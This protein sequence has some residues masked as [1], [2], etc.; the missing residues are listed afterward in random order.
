[1]QSNLPPDHSEDEEG[2]EVPVQVSLPLSPAWW[3]ALHEEDKDLLSQIITVESLLTASNTDFLAGTQLDQ[4]GVPGVYTI[5]GVSTVGD[6]TI[7]ISQGGRTITDGAVLTLR[8]NSEIRENED[9]FFQLVSPTGGRPVINITEVT[10][11]T[12]RIR[13]KF[14]PAFAT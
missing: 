5:W 10:A 7:T 13:V 2:W 14:I 1:M 11:A 6:T 9:T 12:I 3:E 4:P 8:A